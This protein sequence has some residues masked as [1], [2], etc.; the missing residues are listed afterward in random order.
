MFGPDRCDYSGAKAIG[1]RSVTPFEN[2]HVSLLAAGIAR[3]CAIGADDRLTGQSY[4]GAAVAVQD[5]EVANYERSAKTNRG[6]A[7]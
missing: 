7:A 1:R 3:C 4:P 2:G 5:G 6:K